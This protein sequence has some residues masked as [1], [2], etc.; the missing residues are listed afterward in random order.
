MGH[1]GNRGESTGILLDGEML[2][3]VWKFLGCAVNRRLLKGMDIVK[4]SVI[5]T[6]CHYMELEVNGKTSQLV[7][8]LQTWVVSCCLATVCDGH[9]VPW[10]VS[11][12]CASERR[13]T[14]SQP[15]HSPH[16]H[17][18]AA[19]CVLCCKHSSFVSNFAIPSLEN[20]KLTGTPLKHVLE[21]ETISVLMSSTQVFGYTR[22]QN[23]DVTAVVLSWPESMQKTA[24]LSNEPKTM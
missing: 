17:C 4:E 3:G 19:H 24:Y 16:W 5:K 22:F 2:L 15:Q 1:G 9:F 6:K 14:L 8:F 11:F 10:G 21:I 23:S 7:A 12:G 20:H 18:R 13:T